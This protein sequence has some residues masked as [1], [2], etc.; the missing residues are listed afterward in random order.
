MEVLEKDMETKEEACT[1]VSSES[2]KEVVEKEE[3]PLTEEEEGSIKEWNERKKK[4]PQSLVDIKEVCEEDGSKKTIITNSIGEEISNPDLFLSELSLA[5]GSVNIEFGALLYRECIF[6]SGSK[7]PNVHKGIINS[8]RAL[9]PKDEIEGMLITRLLSIHI[10]SM[11]YLAIQSEVK[12]EKETDLYLNRSVKLMRLYNETLEA[13]TRY[14]RKGE[15]R[16]VVQ[17][18]SVND[19]GKAVVNGNLS[20]G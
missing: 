11:N 14:R 13:L 6:A 16:V 15:Q 18:V 2:P 4:T 19:G 20:G 8:L 12:T 3:Q 5:T 9:E 1:A 7:D 10:Q 17:H